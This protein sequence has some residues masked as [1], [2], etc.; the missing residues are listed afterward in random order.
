MFLYFF[1]EIFWFIW[2]KNKI[3]NKINKIN[4]VT[5]FILKYGSLFIVNSPILEFLEWYIFSV[6]IRVKFLEE[7]NTLLSL[8]KI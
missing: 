8:F 2:S 3:I 1:K 4:K 5:F 6:L 7:F